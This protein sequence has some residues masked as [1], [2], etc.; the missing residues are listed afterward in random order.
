MLES[1]ETDVYD[2]QLALGMKKIARHIAKYEKEH[3][4]PTDSKSHG[5]SAEGKRHGSPAAAQIKLMERLKQSH[6]ILERRQQSGWNDGNNLGAEL[7][8]LKGKEKRLKR[9]KPTETKRT[10][11]KP[12]ALQRPSSPLNNGRLNAIFMAWQNYQK[13]ESQQS[14]TKGVAQDLEDYK[15]A[16]ETTLDTY[17]EQI[18][19]EAPGFLE[20]HVW[21]PEDR[22]KENKIA[23]AYELRKEIRPTDTSRAETKSTSH[24][25]NRRK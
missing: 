2:Q 3:R 16:I 9:Q 22:M 24:M 21:L 11:V 15:K 19:N 20:Q 14:E 6:E 18:E 13:L 25:D 4:K 12:K 5:S 7:I 8:N 23:A 1:V 17:I 10:T